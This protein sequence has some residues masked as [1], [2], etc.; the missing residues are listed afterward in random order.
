MESQLLDRAGQAAGPQTD[1]EAGELVCPECVAAGVEKPFV[2]KNKQ[3]LGR[4]R[5]A[6]HGVKSKKPR[7]ARRK[8]AGRKAEPAAFD[9]AKALSLV[10]NGSTT[11]TA[12]QI[13]R[14][15]AWLEEGKALHGSTR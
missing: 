7:Q 13:R 8:T 2:G 4:H 15:A 6:Q 11:M 12:E 1:R 10:A 9:E 3:G 14:T 5:A